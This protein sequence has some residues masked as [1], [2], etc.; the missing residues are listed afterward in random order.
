MF[1]PL[2]CHFP[3]PVLNRVISVTGRS[4]IP[5]S[6]SSTFFDGGRA[7]NGSFF[8]ARPPG[9][10]MQAYLKIA[11]MSSFVK[12]GIPK[13]KDINKQGFLDHSA[14]PYYD[15]KPIEGLLKLLQA[16]LRQTLDKRLGELEE[17]LLKKIKTDLSQLFDPRQQK[18]PVKVLPCID[19]N[20]NAPPKIKVIYKDFETIVGQSMINYSTDIDS[21]FNDAVMV[22]TGGKTPSHVKLITGDLPVLCLPTRIT[23]GDG[24]IV[25]YPKGLRNDPEGLQRSTDY[26][27]VKVGEGAMLRSNRSDIVSLI[28][29]SAK[30]LSK[31]DLGMFLVASQIG[32]RSYKL[33]LALGFELPGGKSPGEIFSCEYIGGECK[34]KDETVK[35]P[36]ILSTKKRPVAWTYL[37]ITRQ[38]IK[39]IAERS[40]Q[41]D[42]ILEA[43]KTEE[44]L[45]SG[46]EK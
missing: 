16:S 30:I 4:V 7:K 35:V 20:G 36:Q 5:R 2:F 37:R 34:I 18:V 46:L 1:K 31:D 45:V 14:A 38:G 21:L 11:P 41:V 27:G 32:S 25:E 13:P 42:M 29:A 8:R 10:A 28:N 15:K 9:F 40:V 24:T 23:W 22:T 19:S 39:D 12:D 3:K 6:K 26:Y 33:L 17:D 43:L 44:D